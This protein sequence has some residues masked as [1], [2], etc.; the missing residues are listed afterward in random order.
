MRGPKPKPV[1]LRVIHGTAGR[2]LAASVPKPRRQL[3][4]CP[5][6]LTGEAQL[7]WKRTAKELYDAGLLTVIDRDALAMYCKAYQRWIEAEAQIA[8]KGTVVVT[9]VKRSPVE[10]DA[11]G[12]IIGGGEVIGGGN[13]IQNPY[14]AIANKA[15]EQMLKLEAEFGMTPSSRMR[16]KADLPKRQAQAQPRAPLAEQDDTRKVLG[17][18]TG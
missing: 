16:V 10:K 8:K 6:F 13:Y 9:N 14:L 2:N 7:C 11:D 12:N 4:R 18:L 17:A 5:D 1:E 15:M 3:P